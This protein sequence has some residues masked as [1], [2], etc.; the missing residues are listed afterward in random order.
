MRETDGISR[1]K[2]NPKPAR[3][4]LLGS[5]VVGGLAQDDSGRA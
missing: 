4:A 5:P 1:C 2:R 3:V